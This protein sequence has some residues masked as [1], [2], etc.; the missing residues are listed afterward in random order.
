MV[1]GKLQVWEADGTSLPEQRL[2]VFFCRL[3][4]FVR[5]DGVKELLRWF[6][7][8]IPSTCDGNVDC[9]FF[10]GCAG[11][12][13]TQREINGLVI[14][15]KWKVISGEQILSATDRGRGFKNRSDVDWS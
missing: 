1:S 4:V 8:V 5:T 11:N 13:A 10:R 7:L 2:N 9:E 3:N 15:V 6:K 14:S 12:L